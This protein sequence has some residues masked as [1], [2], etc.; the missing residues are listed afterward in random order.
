MHKNDRGALLEPDDSYTA[1][2][3]GDK[4]HTFGR[5]S[6]QNLLSTCR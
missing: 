3:F 1:K 4:S 5:K 6:M 2:G